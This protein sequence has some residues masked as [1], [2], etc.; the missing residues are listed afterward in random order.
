MTTG[1][2]QERSANESTRNL[3]SDA[4]IHR[5]FEEGTKLA[6]GLTTSALTDSKEKKVEF[7]VEGGDKIT[8]I[9]MRPELIKQKAAREMYQSP[10]VVIERVMIGQ[11]EIPLGY[12]I[13]AKGLDN[14]C[15]LQSSIGDEYVF[16]A[17]DNKQ[18]DKEAAA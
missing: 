4:L 15:V 7:S 16:N 18:H 5:L 6:K 17:E 8:I 3:M 9:L 14:K 2:S 11:T 13:W 1:S 10:N 12:L